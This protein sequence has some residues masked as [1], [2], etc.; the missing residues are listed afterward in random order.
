[1]N[2]AE[3]RAWG[4]GR[5][6]WPTKLYDESLLL[7][8]MGVL[9]DDGEIVCPECGEAVERDPGWLARFACPCGW[10]LEELAS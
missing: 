6:P 9:R 5:D 1:M 3:R 2:R 10:L 4:I 7:A 8:A